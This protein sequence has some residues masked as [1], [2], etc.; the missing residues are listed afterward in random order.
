MGRDRGLAHPPPPPP[1]TKI[2]GEQDK[3]ERGKR[4][5]RA[6]YMRHIK[7]NT[8][9]PVV[10]PGALHP[11]D[12]RGLQRAKQRPRGHEGPGLLVRS[13]V[14]GVCVWTCV[15]IE[16]PV[17][18]TRQSSLCLCFPLRS[19]D[20]STDRR[21]ETPDP[22]PTSSASTGSN[23]TKQSQTKTN[24]NHTPP[25]PSPQPNTSH[26]PTI[27]RNFRCSPAL[28]LYMRLLATRCRRNGC[29]SPGITKR[30]ARGWSRGGGAMCKYHVGVY[31]GVGVVGCMMS[32]RTGSR[33]DKEGRKEER[34][35]G[36]KEGGKEGPC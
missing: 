36:K 28:G 16:F 5:A 23:Q 6:A 7:I 14:E 31:V 29:G 35:E 13:F 4:P 27:S 3:T 21:I 8:Y 25:P 17:Q 15:G 33:Q 9:A 22:N 10:A 12:D 26:R 19:I 11:E 18:Y 1:P 2:R 34:K 30:M 24:T 20:R 32:A